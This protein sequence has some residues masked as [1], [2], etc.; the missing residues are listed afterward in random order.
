MMIRSCSTY[1]HCARPHKFFYSIDI[2]RVDKLWAAAI[3]IHAGKNCCDSTAQLA[4]DLQPVPLSLVEPQQT[5]ADRPRCPNLRHRR[6]TRIPDGQQIA[7]FVRAERLKN[8]F[9]NLHNHSL[10][11]KYR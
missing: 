3:N 4:S 5:Q 2:G 11:G 8:S 1:L 10:K 6:Q 9:S 7:G